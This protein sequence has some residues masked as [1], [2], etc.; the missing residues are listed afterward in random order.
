MQEH[1]VIL[2]NGI[3]AGIYDEIVC[4]AV[5][6][7]IISLPFTINRMQIADENKRA[8]NIAKGKIAEFL[9]QFFC[10]Q[11]QI[12]VNFD[13]CSTDFWKVDRRD[14]LFNKQEWDLKNNFLYHSGHVLNGEYTQLPALV[15]DRHAYDQWAKR[16][17]NYLPGSQSSCFLFTYMKN[18]GSAG[19]HQDFFGIQLSRKQSGFLQELYTKYQGKTQHKQPFSYEGFWKEMKKRGNTNWIK[20][21]ARPALVI[22]AYAGKNQWNL[23]RKTGIPESPANDLSSLK[24]KCNARG[25]CNYFNG[26]LYTKIVNSAAPVHQLPSFLSLFP[27]LGEN[28]KFADLRARFPKA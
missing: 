17:K 21:N 14:F 3:P 5:R 15:P 19:Q 26:T 9:F 8:K 4:K 10:E 6:Y 23:F 7:A 2:V 16:M 24:M 13:V 25:V 1:E 20:I 18:A 12:P 28:L 11:N 22:T 27:G